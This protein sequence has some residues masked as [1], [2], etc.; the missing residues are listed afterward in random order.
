MS[1]KRS[2]LEDLA[3]PLNR[4]DFAAFVEAVERLP[5]SDRNV[6]AVL[7]AGLVLMSATGSRSYLRSAPSVMAHLADFQRANVDET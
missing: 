1:V 5:A 6:L 3:V 4:R 2:T 7:G